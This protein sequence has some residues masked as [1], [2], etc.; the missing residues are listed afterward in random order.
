NGLIDDCGRIVAGGKEAVGWFDL[1]TLKEPYRIE[2]KKTMGFELAEQLGWDLPDVIFY[3]TGGGTGLIGMWK[4]FAELEAVGLI[5]GRRPRMVAVQASGCAPIVRA[6]EAGVEQ[7]E[8]WEGA[9]TIA[10]GIRVP[11]ALGDFL[12]LRAVRE[13]GGFAIAVPDEAIVAAR[14]EVGRK[15]GML[16][17]P[18]G[19]A[20]FAAWRAAVE[21]GRVKPNERVVLFNCATGLKYPLP[22]AGMRIDRNAPIDYAALAG[23]GWT[24]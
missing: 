11:Q 18:E 2:G 8:R 22:S 14:E 23:A 7:A 16:L 10:A 1:S 6:Y 19:A 17:C 21:F 12:I 9:H 20:T 13:S 4:A 5:G 24:A 3:P 15:E